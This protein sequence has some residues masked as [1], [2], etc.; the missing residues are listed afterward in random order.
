[1][2]RGGEVKRKNNEG[3]RRGDKESER[4]RERV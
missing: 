2:E 1:M 3:E 4:E